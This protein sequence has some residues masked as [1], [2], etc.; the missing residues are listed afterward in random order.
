MN[1]KF[2]LM[3]MSFGITMLVTIGLAVVSLYTYHQGA[4]LR[5]NNVAGPAP[6]ALTALP[7]HNPG[8]AETTVVPTPP[9]TPDSSSAAVKTPEQHD[10]GKSP[11]DDPTKVKN[12]MGE[13]NPALLRSLPA[14]LRNSL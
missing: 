12:Q 8:I 2:K 4:D 11:F 13:N 7:T 6:S 1:T 5:K 9:S 10:N 14:F 3:I